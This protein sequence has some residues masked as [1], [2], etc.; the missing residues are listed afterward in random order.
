MTKDRAEK[1]K[2]KKRSKQRR[3]KKKKKSNDDQKQKMDEG[4][5]EKS[6]IEQHGKNFQ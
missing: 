5:K 6:A 4:M 3:T 1:N 2:A